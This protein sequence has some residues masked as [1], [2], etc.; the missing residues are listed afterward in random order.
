MGKAENLKQYFLTFNTKI[1]DLFQTYRCPHCITPAS[2][3]HHN[4]D[5]AAT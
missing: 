3:P 4:E 1:L 2:F 5:G